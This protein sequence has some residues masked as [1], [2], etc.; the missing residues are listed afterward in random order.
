MLF[1]WCTK[2]LNPSWSCQL[3]LLHLLDQQVDMFF[4]CAMCAAQNRESRTE[5]E[6]NASSNLKNEGMRDD[7]NELDSFRPPS[8]TIGA[9]FVGERGRISMTRSLKLFG[10]L[11][12]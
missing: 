7:T 4:M 10:A 5:N 2:V 11:P 3:A 12:L 8:G 1:S 6:K 9:L